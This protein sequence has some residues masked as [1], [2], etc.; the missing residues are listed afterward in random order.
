MRRSPGSPGGRS[1]RRARCGIARWRI[2]ARS[3]P[4]TTPTFDREHRARLHGARAADHLGHRSEPGARHFRPRARSGRRR[5]RP[6][7][8]DRERAR[9][10]GPAARHGARRPAG[11]SRVHRLVHQRRLPD[12]QAAADVVRGRQRRR[13]RG[14]DG[15]AGLVDGEARG[16]G[17]RP[18]PG[19]PRRRLLLGRIRLLD[20]R[21]RQWRPRRAG[22]ALV[23]TTNRNF[24][25][26]QGPKV[27]THLVSPA[28]AAATAIA[29]RIAD[30]R[31]SWPG[32]A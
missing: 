2:G 6:P 31:Q 16:G 19:V 13:R 3:R 27:R 23:S 22:R 12:L 1:R 4:T 21:R 8:R 28:T 32:G 15:G 24:E 10:Y 18:R 20:V 25:N 5:P 30:V 26:R 9:L 7:R 14:R 11:Q 17:R 29:G